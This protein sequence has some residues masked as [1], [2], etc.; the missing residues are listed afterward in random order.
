M[1]MFAFSEMPALWE[2]SVFSIYSDKPHHRRRKRGPGGGGA[3]PP[4]N[5]RGGANIPF[6]PP[7]PPNNHHIF[8]QFLCKTEKSQCTKLKAKNNNICNFNLI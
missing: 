7:P 1:V 2:K 3:G 4:N 8:L 6:G 5:F